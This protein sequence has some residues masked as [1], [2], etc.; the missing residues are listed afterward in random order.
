MLHRHRKR[1]DKAFVVI[2]EEDRHQLRPQTVSVQSSTT[3]PVNFFRQLVRCRYVVSSWMILGL[4]RLMYLPR[5]C[6]WLPSPPVDACQYKIPSRKLNRWY[7]NTLV[8]AIR[9]VCQ[10]LG[11]QQPPSTQP[12]LPVPQWT[13]RIRSS[14]HCREIDHRA[15]EWC[16]LLIV[17]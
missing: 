14:P 3:A 7:V 6:C 4:F 5:R 9:A 1:V 12:T 11:S 2:H 16:A 13:D 10:R 15:L 8:P 17:Y